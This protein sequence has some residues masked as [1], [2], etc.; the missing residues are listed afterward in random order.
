M[1]MCCRRNRSGI[2]S[3]TETLLGDQHD[4]SPDGTMIDFEKI[5]TRFVMMKQQMG[6]FQGSEYG[7]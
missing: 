2:A 5:N 7:S 6:V 1:L 4:D 3:F